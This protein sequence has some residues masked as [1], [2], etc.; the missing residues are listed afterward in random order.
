MKVSKNEKVNDFLSDL[1]LASP[2]KLEI[3]ECIRSVFASIGQELDED[4]KYGGV[5]Y[6][7]GSTL[8][9]GIFPY[10]NY[11]SIEFS[12]GYKFNDPG[13]VLEGKGK[14]RKTH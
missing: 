7:V 12:N 13:G 1:N 4:M 6:S 3:V 10:A 11:I 2:E 5:V 8:I 9:G 14:K